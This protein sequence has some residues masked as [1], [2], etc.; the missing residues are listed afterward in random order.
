MLQ[1][2]SQHGQTL[3]AKWKCLPSMHHSR[4]TT[5]THTQGEQEKTHE[6]GS[7]GAMG[8][9]IQAL[10]VLHTLLSQAGVH[11][12]GYSDKMATMRQVRLT[13]NYGEKRGPPVCCVRRS[14]A[15]FVSWECPSHPL[16]PLFSIYPQSTGKCSHL[17]FPQLR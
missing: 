7:R 8:F 9:F 5:H 14:S 2:R 1:H 17:T 4:Q 13:V 3:W 15:H 11:T 10:P 6:S 12:S 16:L